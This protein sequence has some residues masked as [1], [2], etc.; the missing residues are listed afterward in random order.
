[1]SATRAIQNRD[2]G[3]ICRD[4]LFGRGQR[5]FSPF[6]RGVVATDALQVGTAGEGN[7]RDQSFSAFV[8]ARYPIHGV[9]PIFAPN[10]EAKVLFRS[11][12]R[13]A[14]G[15]NFG[16]PDGTIVHYIKGCSER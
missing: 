12:F 9:L 3:L 7:N 14:G 13:A 10:A 11:R 16:G 5:A 8:A 15:F 6:H 2:L 4:R 1:M